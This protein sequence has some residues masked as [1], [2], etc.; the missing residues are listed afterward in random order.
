M[1]IVMVFARLL[2]Y[3]PTPTV[4]RSVLEKVSLFI[5]T[6]LTEIDYKQ[7]HAHAMKYGFVYPTAIN[8]ATKLAYS[9]ISSSMF[10]SVCNPTAQQRDL[11]LLCIECSIL[12]LQ[13]MLQTHDSRKILSDDGLLGYLMCLPW[14]L[15]ERSGAEVR[16]KVLASM[17]FIVMKPQPSSLCVIARAKLAAMH[18]G[19]EKVMSVSVQQLMA[20]VYFQPETST[21]I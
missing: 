17:L 11:Q 16:A 8:F 12:H 15:P 6:S 20:E 18:F 5:K 4:D 1:F 9:P 14:N 3:N 21:V 13:H 2:I 7:V 10:S 19:L